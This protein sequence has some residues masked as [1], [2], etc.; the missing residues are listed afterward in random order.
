MRICHFRN[1]N[2]PFISQD[3]FFGKN[4][5]DCNFHAYSDASF[6]DQKWSISPN[7]IFFREKKH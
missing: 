2:K 5:N 3:N 6:S 1:Q 7:M 4:I